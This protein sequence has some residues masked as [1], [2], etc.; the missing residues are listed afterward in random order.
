MKGE[1]PFLWVSENIKQIIKGESYKVITFNFFKTDSI[2]KILIF[3]F[4]ITKF[5]STPVV[6]YGDASPTYAFET[7]EN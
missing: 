5:E 1:S 6:T 7:Q 4:V 3:G 2:Q